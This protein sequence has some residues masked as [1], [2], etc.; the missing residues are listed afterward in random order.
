[1]STAEQPEF[2][3]AEDYLATEELATTKS[4]YIDGWVR[5][6]SGATIRHNTVKVNCLAALHRLLRG[7]PCRPFDSDMRLRIHRSESK[8][9]YYPDVQVVCES[10][11]PTDVFQDQPVLIIEVLS[12]STRVYDLDEKMTAY[13]KI[14]S[15]RC[16]VILEQHI[17]M[18]IVMRRTADGFLRE[19]FEGVDTQI[20]LPFINCTLPLRDI[21]EGIEFTLTGVLETELAYAAEGQQIDDESEPIGK[22]V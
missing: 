2:V 21:Y 11:A 10:N 19:T 14:A 15:L 4:E 1:M 8:R 6:M 12:P 13:L 3:T 7:Q 16:Y 5:A 9:F 18:A 17:P 22:N 20:E